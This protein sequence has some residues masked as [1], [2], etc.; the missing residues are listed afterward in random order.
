MKIKEIK[1]RN[2]EINTK[3]LKEAEELLALSKPR[4][5]LLSVRQGIEQ[6]V[7]ELCTIA[8]ITTADSEGN[9]SLLDL[10]D[11]LRDC[12]TITN[13]FRPLRACHP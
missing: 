13:P 6:I 9:Y 12:R 11:Q 8:N 7:K 4:H 3:Y 1:V 10:I 5:V 2:Q